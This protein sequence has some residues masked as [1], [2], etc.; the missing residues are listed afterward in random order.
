MPLE[1]VREALARGQIAQSLDTFVAFS[2]RFSARAA[3]TA[4]SSAQ[5]DILTVIQQQRLLDVAEAKVVCPWD[6]L[7][8]RLAAEAPPLVDFPSRLRQGQPLAVM[9]EIKRASPS[10]GDI[11]LHIEAG[12]QALA[13]ARGGAAAISVLTEPTWFKV[14]QAAPNQHFSRLRDNDGGG[15][16]SFP[17]GRGRWRT[18]EQPGRPW[19]CWGPRSGQQSCARIFWWTHTR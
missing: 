6:T 9:A 4:G 16:G 3:A 17:H 15:R 7:R 14:G 13:Y 18:C 1:Q 19:M 10:K 2:R 8:A 12:P 11:A 5:Q